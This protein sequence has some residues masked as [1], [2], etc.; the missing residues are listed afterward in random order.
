[1]ILFSNYILD[2]RF[3]PWFVPCEFCFR[4][5]LVLFLTLTSISHIT[6]N[7]HYG[8]FISCNM[9]KDVH[10][11]VPNNIVLKKDPTH[12]IHLLHGK[13][14]IFPCWWII[15]LSNY[16]ALQCSCSIYR[17]LCHVHAKNID[18]VNKRIYFAVT[19]LT[20]IRTIYSYIYHIYITLCS[21]IHKRND[22]CTSMIPFS[23]ILSTV[24]IPKA[25]EI[26]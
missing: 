20:N 19:I 13:G 17:F 1:M 11:S 26:A 12:P 9:K 23:N 22:V 6:L 7:L 5:N 4:A 3:S 24:D 8:L 15:F 2:F 21:R 10:S 18:L 14:N 25:F 16:S